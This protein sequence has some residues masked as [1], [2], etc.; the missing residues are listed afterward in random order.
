M[1]GDNSTAG[2]SSAG[3]D[4]T[5]GGEGSG[6]VPRPG[7]VTAGIPWSAPLPNLPQPGRPA[8]KNIFSLFAPHVLGRGAPQ[9]EP[10]PEVIV[11]FVVVQCPSVCLSVCPFICL[12]VRPCVCFSVCLSVC[13]F[14]CRA[15]SCG[16]SS[17]AAKF[18]FSVEVWFCHGI[19]QNFT[20]VK[21]WPMISTE[22]PKTA[23]LLLLLFIGIL[24]ELT[25]F[26]LLYLYSSLSVYFSSSIL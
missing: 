10:P 21:K 23:S 9:D 17:Q 12:Y 2:T 11:V 13:M 15:H 1:T 24:G 25:I 20:E 16:I 18:A 26:I 19:S 22:L 4:R 5:G 8:I 3:R 6:G 14:I 7:P